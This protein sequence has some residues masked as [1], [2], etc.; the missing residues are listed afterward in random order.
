MKVFL[1]TFCLGLTFFLPSFNRFILCLLSKREL[2][3]Y[4][5]AKS[6]Y[7]VF[8]SSISALLQ[9]TAWSALLAG[10]FWLAK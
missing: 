5:F 8:A 6:T 3:E 2:E 7:L 1:F 4:V 9:F 10:F